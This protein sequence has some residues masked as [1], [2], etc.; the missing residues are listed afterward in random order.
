MEWPVSDGTGRAGRAFVGEHRWCR[1]GAAAG[2]TRD[3]AT[4]QQRFA[5][6]VVRMG[7]A[8]I[9]VAP[10][11]IPAR[12][13][14]PS[15]MTS[16]QARLV[17]DDIKQFSTPSSGRASLFCCHHR[18]GGDPVALRDARLDPGSALR[19]VR[20]DVPARRCAPSGMT[21]EFSR[22][23]RLSWPVAS[24]RSRHMASRS[25]C[26]R[27]PSTSAARVASAQQA[28]AGRCRRGGDRP[29]CRAGCGRWPVRKHAPAPSLR[30]A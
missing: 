15:G 12:P 24:T 9:G 11:W 18:E 26:V 2:G 21:S 5:T 22:R 3:P 10:V 23:S 1:P 17:R 20:D 7:G 28:E 19:A 13:C 4:W 29:S 8:G 16:N 14:G 30:S 27:Q 25:R 6:R